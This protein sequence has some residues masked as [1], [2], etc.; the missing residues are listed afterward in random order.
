MT[1]LNCFCRAKVLVVVNFPV[2]YVWKSGTKS[3]TQRCVWFKRKRNLGCGKINKESLLVWLNNWVQ[4]CSFSI[5]CNT[6]SSGL[7]FRRV[8]FLLYYKWKKFLKEVWALIHRIFLPAPVLKKAM[9]AHLNSIVS[10][11]DLK[12][13]FVPIFSGQ[14]EWMISSHL[15]LSSLCFLL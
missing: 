10:F 6:L 3:Q 5:I 8:T 1:Y 11:W 9:R 13:S 4:D 15:F 14:F 7:R 12:N 2:A